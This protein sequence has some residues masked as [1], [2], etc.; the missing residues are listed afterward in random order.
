VIFA[1]MLWQPW[2]YISDRSIKHRLNINDGSSWN[3]EYPLSVSRE[4]IRESLKKF[5]E[6]NSRP[7]PE[8][9]INESADVIFDSAQRKIVDLNR[10]LRHFVIFAVVPPLVVFLFGAT[11]R[12]ALAGFTESA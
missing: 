7:I 12:W 5:F 6:N 3:F 2:G 4:E 9:D 10:E 1:V 11:V 8:V